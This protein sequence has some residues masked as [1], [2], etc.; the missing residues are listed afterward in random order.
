VAGAVRAFPQV[1]IGGPATTDKGNEFLRHFLRHCAEGKNYLSG[2]VGTKLDFIS[3]H[4]KGAYYTPRR[5]YGQEV[6]HE[7]PSLRKIISDIRR[8]LEVISEFSQFHQLPV[9]V[10][11]CDP[12]V[13]TVYGV[14]DNPNFVVCNTEYYPAFVAAMV[15]QIL[16]LNETLPAKV[17]RIT[18]WAFYFEGKRF[19]EGNRTLVTN[20]NIWNPIMAGLKM[21]GKLGEKRVS[22]ASSEA[23]DALAENYNAKTRLVDGLATID[24]S[25]QTLSVLIWRHCDDWAV[26]DQQQISLQ[27][28]NLPFAIGQEVE[29]KQW[30]IDGENSNA[31]AEWLAMGRPEGPTPE[32]LDQLRQKQQLA[33]IQQSSVQGNS[34]LEFNLELPT[35]AL[36]LFEIGLKDNRR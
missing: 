4:T 14:Y 21:L 32:Q 15:G 31:Y 16:K 27:L 25:K 28:Q 11:E 6:P 19:F 3:F 30:R 9:F 24:A 13:G 20:K 18:H 26:D 5:S 17:S 33:L 23:G 35:Q 7:F 12:A 8:S 29:I 10:D 2:T 36:A 22:L 1:K 34:S